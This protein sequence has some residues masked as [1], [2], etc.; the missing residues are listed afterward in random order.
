LLKSITGIPGGAELL[1][2]HKSRPG[3]IDTEGPQTVVDPSGASA[4]PGKIMCTK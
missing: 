1:L 2:T 4:M 3:T